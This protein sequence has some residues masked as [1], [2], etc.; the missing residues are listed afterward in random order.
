M[1]AKAHIAV[2]MAAAFT[3]MRP[4][5]IPEALPVVTGAAIGCLICDLDC[6]NPR[7]RT[8]SSHYRIAMAVLAAAALICNL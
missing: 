7:E 3:I 8:E 1:M 2:G 5:S 4:G 6:E